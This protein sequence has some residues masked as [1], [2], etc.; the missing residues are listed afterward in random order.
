MFFTTT[1]CGSRGFAWKDLILPRVYSD[2]SSYSGIGRSFKSS[3]KVGY[4][5]QKRPYTT[6]L[7]Y[8][9]VANEK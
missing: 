8:K 6:F 7:I 9:N 2:Y 5:Q 3:Q 1:I 4:W